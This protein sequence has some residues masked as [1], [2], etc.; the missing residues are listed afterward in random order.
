[1]LGIMKKIQKFGLSR[2]MNVCFFI[3][4]V[5]SALLYRAETWTLMK[6]LTNKLDECYT[7]M[8]C[9]AFDVESHN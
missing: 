1:M 7:K 4:T 5:E 9:M 3:S 2:R 6:A 8:L